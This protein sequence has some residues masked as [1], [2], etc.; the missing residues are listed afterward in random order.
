MKQRIIAVAVFLLLVLGITTRSQVAQWFHHLGYYRY[1]SNN[2]VEIAPNI[3]ELEQREQYDADLAQYQRDKFNYDDMLGAA[4]L[5]D[6]KKIAELKAKG[7]SEDD[8]EGEVEASEG[9]WM[10]H[11]PQPP[12]EPEAITKYK[13]LTNQGLSVLP[14]FST[15]LDRCVII[16]SKDEDLKSKKIAQV[17][18]ENHYRDNADVVRTN[19]VMVWAETQNIVPAE[20]RPSVCQYYR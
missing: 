7:Y 11:P 10:F 6:G 17:V 8:A 5:E 4:R 16:Y 3:A 13:V 19:D 14:M 18:V 1:I 15:E 12:K 20:P 9:T 2:T